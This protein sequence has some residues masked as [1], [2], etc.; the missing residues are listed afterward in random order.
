M[1]TSIHYGLM[2]VLLIL[3]GYTAGNFFYMSSKGGSFEKQDKIQ[4]LLT[5]IVAHTQLIL[6]ILLLF[7]GDRQI[8]SYYADMG[9]LMKDSYQRFFAI[10]HPLTMIIG[11]A[12]IT[13][14]YSTAKR[15]TD[16]RAKFKRIAIFYLLALVIIAIRI[17]W[18][19][20]S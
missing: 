6:G 15:M 4:A 9:T 19:Y 1:L 5:L 12:L 2:I 18:A 20:I 11:I 16:D 7:I 3:L 14:G 10:E 8:S 13:V 17:P